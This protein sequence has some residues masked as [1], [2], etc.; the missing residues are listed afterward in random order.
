[1]G[2]EAV[3][4]PPPMSQTKPSLGYQKPEGECW[5]LPAGVRARMSHE[6]GAGRKVLSILRG[7]IQVTH[8]PPEADS[9]SVGKFS[10]AEQ[11]PLTPTQLSTGEVRQDDWEFGPAW[12]T[13]IKPSV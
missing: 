8:S 11:H 2:S 13:V 6:K 10:Q 4:L 7:W 5:S 1:M 3:I 12:A 9:M